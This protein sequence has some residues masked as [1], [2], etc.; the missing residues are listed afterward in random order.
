MVNSLRGAGILPG[1]PAGFQPDVPPK[2]SG[3]EA[4][5]PRCLESRATLS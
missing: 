5:W 4:H 3:L 1:W 2:I